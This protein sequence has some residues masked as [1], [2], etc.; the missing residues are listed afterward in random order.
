MLLFGAAASFPPWGPLMYTWAR[1]GQPPTVRM[2]GTRKGEKVFGLMEYC[3]GRFFLKGKKGVSIPQRTLPF[4]GVCWR[5]TTP[6]I[7]L[8][9]EGA[10]YGIPAPRPQPSSPSRRLG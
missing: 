5:I 3:T 7:L 1:R 4:S 8:M 9:Q 10:R 2:F 6:P